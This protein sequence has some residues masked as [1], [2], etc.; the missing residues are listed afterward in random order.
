MSVAYVEAFT[1]GDKQFGI[2]DYKDG[3]P[4]KDHFFPETFR[5]KKAQR[6]HVWAGGCGIGQATTIEKAR[7]I[8]V[9]YARRRAQ[10]KV[11]EA[12]NFLKDADE[13]LYNLHE[14]A[15]LFRFETKK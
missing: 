3:K 9:D 10:Q 15:H 7:E 2:E 1:I 13:V 8:I 6:F 5:A 14:T 11:I 4:D 12:Q